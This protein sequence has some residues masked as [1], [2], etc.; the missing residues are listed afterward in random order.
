MIVCA[1]GVIKN[2]ESPLALVVSH[3]RFTLA[4]LQ[5]YFGVLDLGVRQQLSG[6]PAR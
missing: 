3:S 5:H 4:G 2:G 1:L 6:L